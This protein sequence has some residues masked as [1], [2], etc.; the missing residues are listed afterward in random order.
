MY[1]NGELETLMTRF[2]NSLNTMPVYVGGSIERAD[3][4]EVET[5]EGR[6]SNRYMHNNYYNNGN[7]NQMFLMY[8]HGYSFGKLA[9]H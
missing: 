7:V 2:E 4:V 9:A 8:L 1:S 6:T 3:K 5:D